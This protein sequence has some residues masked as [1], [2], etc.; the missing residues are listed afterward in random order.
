MG[1][2]DLAGAGTKRGKCRWQHCGTNAT[3]KMERTFAKTKMLYLM[4]LPFLATLA[5]TVPSFHFILASFSSSLSLA[6]DDK[7]LILMEQGVE[8]VG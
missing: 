2:K 3:H 7:C 5:K 6:H 4:Q 8:A 1:I